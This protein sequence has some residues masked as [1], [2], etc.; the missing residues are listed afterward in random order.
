MV[1]AV[2]VASRDERE[3][4]AFPFEG[5]PIR[6]ALRH[7]LKGVEKPLVHVVPV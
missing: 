3:R 6:D 2:A 7:K 4:S 1:F 5:Y